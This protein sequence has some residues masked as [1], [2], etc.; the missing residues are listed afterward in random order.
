MTNES[1]S[2][3]KYAQSSWTSY[4]IFECKFT[5]SPDHVLTVTWLMFFYNLE[6]VGSSQLKNGLF[7]K[8]LET[9]FSKQVSQLQVYAELA[10][11]DQQ[12]KVCKY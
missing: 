10:G 1:F 5:R 6:D 9:L 4:I 11:V 7:T 3:Y 8:E 2:R 12:E